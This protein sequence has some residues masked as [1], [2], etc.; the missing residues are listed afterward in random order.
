MGGLYWKK[1]HKISKTPS[2]KNAPTFCCYKKSFLAI[3]EE[4]VENSFC[5]FCYLFCTPGPDSAAV[6]RA[7]GGVNVLCFCMQV[8][9]QPSGPASGLRTAQDPFL[10]EFASQQEVA[11]AGCP[12]WWSVFCVFMAAESPRDLV[13]LWIAMF[14]ADSHQPSSDNMNLS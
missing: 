2:L 7:P 12:F 9:G 13:Q 3:W 4:F 5:V 11:K 8:V 1:F 10:F 6:T 14:I